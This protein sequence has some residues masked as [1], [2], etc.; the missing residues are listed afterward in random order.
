MAEHRRVKWAQTGKEIFSGNYS[1]HKLGEN[2][3]SFVWRV[4]RIQSHSQ[5]YNQQ[6]K[7]RFIKMK[8]QFCNSI[9]VGIQKIK[10]NIEGKP[11]LVQKLYDRDSVHKDSFKMI[12]KCLYRQRTLHLAKKPDNKNLASQKGIPWHVQ[13]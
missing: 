7:D 11:N 10:G 13:S 3:S 8:R 5:C 4:W 9:K 2:F 1:S 6:C 12:C